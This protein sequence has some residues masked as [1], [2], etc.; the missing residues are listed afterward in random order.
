MLR[1]VKGALQ[2]EA[3][4]QAL[5]LLPQCAVFWPQMHTLLVAD[6]HLGKAAAFRSGGIPVPRGTTN[7]NL[8]LLLPNRNRGD[9]GPLAGDP[10]G[11]VV[12]DNKVNCG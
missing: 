3:A 9:I 11:G 2:I 5:W 8:A 4:G 1:T 7:E 12:V 6:A 10:P